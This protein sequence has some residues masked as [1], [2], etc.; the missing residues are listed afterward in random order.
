MDIGSIVLTLALTLLAALYIGMPFLGSR[1]PPSQP[2]NYPARH[3][4]P[5]A[6]GDPLE[7]LIAARRKLHQQRHDGDGE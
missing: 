6:V 7:D 1:Q 5:A 2:E 4:Q 3:E